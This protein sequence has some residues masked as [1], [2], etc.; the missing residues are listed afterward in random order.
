ML[1]ISGFINYFIE[2]NKM[3]KIISLLMI[4]LFIIQMLPTSLAAQTE[5]IWIVRT[6][7]I[8][9]FE[10]LKTEQQE[11]N[12][13]GSTNINTFIDEPKEGFN[14][15]LIDLT[16]SKINMQKQ[17]AIDLT[18][19]TL[20]IGENIY[21]RVENDAFLKNHN[22]T[23]ITQGEVLFGNHSGILLFEVSDSDSSTDKGNWFVTVD[24]VQ[25]TKG[26]ARDDVVPDID[27]TVVQHQKIET[28]LLDAYNLQGKSSFSN[29]YVVK[30]PYGTAPL[31]ALA[32]FETDYAAEISVLVKGKTVDADI[33]YIIDGYNTHHVIQIFGLYADYNNTVVLTSKTRDGT[34]QT[35]EIN[36][37]TEPVPTYI[38]S[39]FRV[40]N[41]TE[42][43][44]IMPGLTAVCT[45]Y[46]AVLDC[47]AE[48]RWYTTIQSTATTL[49][50]FSQD[51]TLWFST[52]GDDKA[53]VI[54]HMSFSGKVL[55]EYHYDNL[56]AHHDGTVLPNGNL[57]YFTG[58]TTLHQIN[59]TTG[60]ISLY[61][62]LNDYMKNIG[63]LDLRAYGEKSDWLH[64]N[65]IDYFI[66]DKGSESLILSIRNQS[67]VVKL[68]YPDLTI[69]WVLS[70]T[71][72]YQELVQSCFEGKYITKDPTDE[73][74]EW[75]YVQHEPVVLPNID[76]NPNTTDLL[77]FDNGGKRE[78][79]VGKGTEE[80]YSRVVHYQIDHKNNMVR[81][82]TDFGDEFGETYYCD[83]N[84]GAQYLENGNLFGCFNTI[85]QGTGNWSKIVETDSEGDILKV[86]EVNESAY[87]AYRLPVQTFIV[88]NDML[89]EE[90]GVYYKQHNYE[91]EKVNADSNVERVE[92]V[93]I[94]RLQI[95]DGKLEARF[96]L[97][98]MT[99]GKLIAYNDDNMY[100]LILNCQNSIVSALGA[101]ISF[102]DGEYNLCLI[103]TQNG[104]EKNFNIDKKL[105]LQTD[106]VQKQ[107]ILQQ[108]NEF[109]ENQINIIKSSNWT[110]SKPNI[111]VDPYGIAPLSAIASFK[112]SKPAS[113][114]VEIES[115]NGATNVTNEFE[116]LSIEHQIPIYGLYA[117]EATNVKLTANYQ[118]GTSE[119]SVVSITGNSLPSDFV[120]VGVEKADA[121]QMADGWTFIMAGSLQGY[122]YAI[123]ETG[124][125]RWILSEKGL[126][127]AG[128][129]L[130]LSN[131][132]YLIGGDKSF[133]QYYKYNLF[134]LNMTGQIINEYLVNGYHHDAQEL[135]NG[136]LLILANNVNGDVVEDTM[137]EIERSTGAILRTWDLNSYFNVGNYNNA[138]QHVSDINYGSDTHDWLHTNGMEYDES[139]NSVLIS[140]R[141]QD[142]VFSMSLETGDINWI[143]SNPD[144]LWPEYLKEKLLK[145]TGNNF[146]WQY[147]QHNIS[148][149]PNGDIMMF[150][151]GDY[152]SKNTN[153][154]LPAT[155]GYSRAVVYRIDKENM[156]VSQVWQ[157][158]KE[159]GSV[160]MAAYVSSSQYLDENH[161]LIDFGGIVKDSNGN[162]TYNI[163]DG[164]QGSS[165]SQI[166]EVKDGKI[167]FHASVERSGLHGN[168]YRAAR[169]MP[170][171]STAELDLTNAGNRLGSLY[172][173]GL[174]ETVKFDSSIAVSGAPEVEVS[175]NGI[176]LQITSNLGNTGVK[177]N[178]AI[179][180]ANDESA[181]K[182]T[183]PSDT[184]IAY[185]LN[186]SEIPT[187][188]YKLYLVKDNITYDLKLEWTNSSNYGAF[189]TAYNVA[190]K[191]NLPDD[192]VYGSGIYYSNTPFTISAVTNDG[193]KFEGWY[194]GDELVST[195]ANHTIIA[196]S[197][198]TITAK[199][200]GYTD[201]KKTDWYYDAVNYVNNNGIMTG[202]SDTKFAPNDKL[203]RAQAC[204]V[205]YN[206]ANANE[207]AT[208]AIFSDVPLGQWYTNAISWASK[209][210]V[211]SGYG[212]NL[213]GP[214]DAI[215]REQMAAILY[216]Y[217]GAP[218]V[219]ADNLENYTDAN[220]ISDW[221]T[222]ALN[223]CVENKI[224]VGNGNGTMT[225]NKIISRAEVATIMMNY[226]T[227][228][229]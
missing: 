126:G 205:I 54:Y 163:M 201:V 118:D 26:I 208:E 123:D 197:D 221:A 12:Y 124:A 57:V 133:G 19:T 185:T 61:L 166:Y 220:K 37:E 115:K 9:V 184:S 177:S 113:I 194:I 62:D 25:A 141:H 31:T 15:V 41:E 97:Q 32:L 86:I 17:Q 176:Q 30:N 138:G 167:V 151:N 28:E 22:F 153:E 192:L 3:K 198:M 77:L 216:R 65:T 43:A 99:A 88:P 150:D 144:D 165:Q 204:Q 171:S 203:S 33:T 75:F 207:Q 143:L 39:Q 20:K 14:Y 13:D 178:L 51:G 168:T 191:S 79:V 219:E 48:I 188:T 218:S 145:P 42:Q 60:E 81:Q 72:E 180:F 213:F 23:T 229:K 85:A 103:L 196:T 44:T 160:P 69:D 193:Y 34:T 8:Q 49:N 108:Q 91:W 181:Y 131:G 87:R 24:G 125:V 1:N 63:S 182:V 21:K 94:Q 71:V 73:Q 40:A 46:R 92:D 7:K 53:S 149:L 224:M 78:V 162:A 45:A 107:D 74:F 10:K 195:D 27:N 95:T 154:V 119:T 183:L 4:A 116:T 206:I 56:E 101:N 225:P 211:V 146:E 169:M 129:L 136:N 132:N 210:G 106:V 159:L 202:Y 6:N 55:G 96:Y 173:Y 155:E 157:F 70:P 2:V 89:F 199:F 66:D 111:T 134:E 172:R 35:K 152:R 186:N 93:A 5:Q 175:D 122:V 174:V 187:G 50:E 189:P 117:G 38:N 104:I 83:V 158:G 84:G 90:Q 135:P 100:E 82:I 147:G 127:A 59:P 114:Y 179:I 164:I 76:K 11:V 128:S 120:P 170:Y 161:Y 212:N 228:I 148:L 36:I 80:K 121:T 29:P 102:V 112:T 156:T 200:S 142:A 18:N 130:P 217:V 227:N 64:M 110:I 98:G 52:N 67:M 47:N 137:Y 109:N 226:F 105:L 214:D 215:T 190:V 68:N 209:N 16:V 222:E 58:R 139:T 223:W 140:A